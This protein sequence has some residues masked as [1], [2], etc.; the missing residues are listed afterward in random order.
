[1]ST[2]LQISQSHDLHTTITSNTVNETNSGY[3]TF[4]C[5]KLLSRYY[6]QMFHIAEQGHANGIGGDVAVGL[7]IQLGHNG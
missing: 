4:V 2:F 1:M 6:K 7:S 5:E 3:S